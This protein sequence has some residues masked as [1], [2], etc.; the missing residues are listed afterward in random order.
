MEPVWKRARAA[1]ERRS[2]A[3]KDAAGVAW[4]CHASRCGRSLARSGAARR[5]WAFLDGLQVPMAPPGL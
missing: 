5:A 3:G 2:P 1:G 4:L